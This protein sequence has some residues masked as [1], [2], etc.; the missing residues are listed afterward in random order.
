MYTLHTGISVTLTLIHIYFRTM[1][2]SA[3]LTFPLG[4]RVQAM[5]EKSTVHTVYSRHEAHAST[6]H[7]RRDNLPQ[8]LLLLLLA[9]ST[10][11]L[12][13]KALLYSPL[14]T[15]LQTHLCELS[16]RNAKMSNPSVHYVLT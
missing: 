10:Y 11:R 5:T 3:G 12:R 16:L 6:A 2:D 1:S 7:A 14:Y 4:K 8:P 9:A 13:S 15:T